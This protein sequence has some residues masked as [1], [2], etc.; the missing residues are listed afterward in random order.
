MAKKVKTGLL[1]V[2][3][4][5]SGMNLTTLIIESASN[6]LAVHFLDVGQADC[7]LIQTPS[8]QNILI[9]AGETGDAKFVID[10]LHKRGVRRIDHLVATHPHADHIGGMV[11][12]LNA[13]DIGKL[14]M[15]RAVHTTKTFENLL[16]AIE[17][18][19]LKMTEAKAGVVMDVGESVSATFIAPVS[20]G[21]RELNDYS[22]VIKLTFGS[23]DFLFM[24]DAETISE[25]EILATGVDLRADVLKVG[26]H[27]SNTSSSDAFLEAVAP[28][29]AVICVGKDNRY[30]LPTSNTLGK[31]VAREITILRTDVEGTI[32][33]IS[34][35]EQ[36]QVD[37]E[38]EE[39]A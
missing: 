35:G 28:T 15:P 8:G 25:Q 1:I 36:I 38:L 11:D 37:T 3:V 13:F 6:E 10:Y 27:G 21:Y 19:G 16:L 29:Y 4:L 24:G 5:L 12:V 39:A 30:G 18:K 17:A 23:T 7:I 33:I 9:D 20:T 22:A 34:D 26:H 2:M 14:Y 32:V 31:L